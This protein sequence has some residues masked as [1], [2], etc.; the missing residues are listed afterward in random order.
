MAK[1]TAKQQVI[2]A[3]ETHGWKARWKNG[4]LRLEKGD[5]EM[6]VGFTLPGG[7]NEVSWRATART[8]TGRLLRFRDPNKL[9]LI[10]AE[11]AKEE[12]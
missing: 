11:L 5:R 6:T 3:A 12:K 2:A 1:Q 9:D 4:W 10:L 7:V 8:A